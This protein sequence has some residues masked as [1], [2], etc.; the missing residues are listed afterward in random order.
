[1]KPKILVVE[2]NEDNLETLTAYLEFAHYQTIKASNG[3]IALQL[4]TQEKPDVIFLDLSLPK[5]DGWEVA[6][7]IKSNPKT[8]HTIIIAFSAMALSQEKERALECGCD[9]FMAK[10]MPPETLIAEM[11][12]ILQQNS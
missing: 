11:N 12:K 10:P 3:E 2:D 1:M 8:K 6:R 7:Q 9:A 4:V 5:V